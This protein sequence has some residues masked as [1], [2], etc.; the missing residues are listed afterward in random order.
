[1]VAGRVLGIRSFGKAAFLVL[2]D[3]RSRLQVYVRQDALSERD[4]AASRLLD[5]GDHV[6]VAGHLF[7]TKT[8]ELSVWASSLDVPRQVLPAA[9]G[10]VARPAATSRRATGSATS[11]WS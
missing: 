7:R 9:A 3:G 11:I 2:S 5:F 1:M 6:G 10:E 8:D 4:F